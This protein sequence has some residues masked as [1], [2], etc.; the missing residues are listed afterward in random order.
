WYICF[1]PRLSALAI[2]GVDE[3]YLRGVYAEDDNFKA[4]LRMAEISELY[5]GR[6]QL[7]GTTENFI[8]GI[9]QS[10][11]NEKELYKKQDRASNFWNNGAEINRQRWR[12]FCANPVMM[13]NEGKDWGSFDYILDEKEYYL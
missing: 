5:A 3:E 11:L 6:R 12:N 10:H 13:A 9:H 4:R 7:N 2:G 1:F 8:V